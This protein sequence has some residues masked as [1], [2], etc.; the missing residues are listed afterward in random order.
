MILILLTS[1]GN[2]GMLVMPL[3]YLYKIVPKP[4]VVFILLT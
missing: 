1:P 2:P 3:I 4:N